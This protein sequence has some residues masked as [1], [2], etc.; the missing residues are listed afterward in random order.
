MEKRLFILLVFLAVV[1]SMYN[2]KGYQKHFDTYQKFSYDH[3]FNK[4]NIIE[5][6]KEIIVPFFELTLDTD[7]LKRGYSVYH[8]KGQCLLCHGVRGEGNPSKQG[9]SLAQ[10]FPWYIEEQLDLFKQKKR[11]NPEMLPYLLKLT[12]QDKKD[13]AL[14]ISKL[15]IHHSHLVKEEKPL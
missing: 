13:V 1:I 9:P 8:E 3:F 5:E 2:L 14:Y 15:K 12:D 4:E 10:Q 7:D 11:D 6:K